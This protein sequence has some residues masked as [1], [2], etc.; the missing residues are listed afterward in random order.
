MPPPSPPAPCYN[1]PLDQP[2]PLPPTPK[3]GY[4]VREDAAE[5]IRWLKRSVDKRHPDALCEMSAC[6]MFGLGV[7][8]DL[9]KALKLAEAALQQVGIGYIPIIVL[10]I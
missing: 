3:Q 1:P 10:Y 5:G 7:A 6:C 2:P 4:G 9:G 8:R